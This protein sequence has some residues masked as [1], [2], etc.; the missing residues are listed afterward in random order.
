[1]EA[2]KALALDIGPR[3]RCDGEEA[4]SR[5]DLNWRPL[6]FLIFFGESLPAVSSLFVDPILNAAL[7][8]SVSEGD[9]A[10]AL[11]GLELSCGLEPRRGLP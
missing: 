4:L 10:P 7:T 1:M 11:E 2:E 3:S 6:S 5:F 8:P 9:P